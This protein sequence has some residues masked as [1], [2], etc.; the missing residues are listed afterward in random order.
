MK[1]VLVTGATGNVGRH[2]VTAVRDRGASVRAFV[3]DAEK[4]RAKLGDDVELAVGDFEDQ[5]SL[6]RAMQGVET[7]FLTSADGPRKV[8]HEKAVIDAAA[9]HW[10]R[11]VVK[12]SSPH[13]EIG[14]DLVF[15]DWHGQIERHLAD[16]DVPAV[17]LRANFLMSGLLASAEAVRATGKL[18]A[19][20]GD[21]KIAMIDPRDIGAAAAVLLIEDGHDGKAYTLTG[22]V[23]I[24]FPQVAEAL[25]EVTG[26]A[27]EFV[28][29]GPDAARGAMLDSGMPGWLA[30]ALV[31]LYEKLRDDVCAEV[32][33][34]VHALTGR[35]PRSFAD[36]AREHAAAFGG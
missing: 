33:E 4:A 16:A 35:P 11:R 5:A 6:R 31:T 8:E 18:F 10:V 19:P 36:W 23:A 21:A 22:P 17:Y 24:T 14:S 34:T 1:K 28:D 12:L 26:R 13:L 27:V 15:W 25:S 20:A 29:V 30:D 7:V 2:V 9:A 3:R 32:N